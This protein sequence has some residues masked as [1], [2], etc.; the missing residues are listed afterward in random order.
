[1]PTYK[2]NKNVKPQGIGAKYKQ[3]KAAA[4][5]TSGYGT[6][7]IAWKDVAKL[8]DAAA[9]KQL[10]KTI[11]TQY[12]QAMFRMI[13]N[14]DN[15]DTQGWALRGLNQRVPGADGIRKLQLNAA[16]I[17]N[18]G[19]LSQVGQTVQPGFRQGQRINA[20]HLAFTITGTLPQLTADCS[21]HWRVVRRKNDA[22]GNLAYDKPTITTM[23]IVGLFKSASDG[24]FAS[25]I[26]YG[27]SDVASATAPIPGHVSAM[28]QNTDY[29]TFVKGAHGYK[30]IKAQSLDPDPSDQKHTFD[31]CEKMYVPLD[32]EWDFITKGGCDIKGGNYFFV[33]WREG[34]QDYTAAS[35]AVSPAG[36]T[37][38]AP[39]AI[40]HISVWMELAFKDG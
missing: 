34:A 5:T 40:Q 7:S 32:E 9:S 23:D 28:R 26:Q 18:L 22:Q 11:E 3:K 8:V 14:E 24:P 30:T 31:F 38:G 29:W 13:Y 37:V 12:S 20:K 16:V 39:K 33:L 15:T 27:Q 35:Q 1:M 10:N 19:Y 25:S 36:G 2:K 21:Y 6:K 17:F 4:K